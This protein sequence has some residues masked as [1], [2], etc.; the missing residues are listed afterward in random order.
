MVIAIIGILVAL[1]LPAVQT[2]REAAR[3]MQCQNNLKQMGLAVNLYISAQ[4]GK[5]PAGNVSVCDDD[6]R[7]CAR[8]SWTWAIMPFIELRALHDQYDDTLPNSYRE[9]A[10]MQ[11]IAQQLNEFICPTDTFAR[12][13]LATPGETGPAAAAGYPGLA[14]SSYK[15]VAGALV[16]NPNNGIPVWRDRAHGGAAQSAGAERVCG[17]PWSRCIPWQL[18]LDTAIKKPSCGRSKTARRRRF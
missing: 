2:A 16:V 17:L 3:R 14:A 5:L 1:L 18:F 9:P 13:L 12:S 7:R 6:Q 15:G 10:N 4:Q 8:S 11:V